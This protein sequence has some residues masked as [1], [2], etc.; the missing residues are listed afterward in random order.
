MDTIPVELTD[1]FIELLRRGV[2]VFYVRR[3]TLFKEVYERFGVKNKE[4]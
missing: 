2:R 4:R 1:G 3:L